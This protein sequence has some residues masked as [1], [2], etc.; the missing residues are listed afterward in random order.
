[1]DFQEFAQWYIKY[2]NPEDEVLSSLLCLWLCPF[3]LSLGSP[4]GEPGINQARPGG[5]LK[6]TTWGSAAHAGFVVCFNVLSG[7]HEHGDRPQFVRERKLISVTVPCVSPCRPLA[8]QTS[9]LW[10]LLSFSVSVSVSASIPYHTSTEGEAAA[11]F[12]KVQVGMKPHQTGCNP[13]V[14]PLK[15]DLGVASI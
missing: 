9:T 12:I 7:A 3:S 13:I 1:V 14:T 15:E 11:G 6:A 10:A 5:F 4:Q 2:F 8:V